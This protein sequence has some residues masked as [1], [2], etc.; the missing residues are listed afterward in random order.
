MLNAKQNKFKARVTGKWT[1]R[2]FLLWK[3]PIALLSGLQIRALD[4]N[5]SIVSIPYKWL[6]Q[7]PFK[8]IYFAS[9]A[10]AAEMSTGVLGMLAIQGIAPVSMLV[11]H[12]ECTFVKKATSRVWFT[13][14]NGSEIFEAVRT[15]LETGEGVTVKC[16][17]TGRTQDGTIVS[18]FYI[19][20]T[21]KR[22]S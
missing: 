5:H 3:L 1:F 19:T 10:M 4:E 14:E 2:L 22:R 11:L 17:A 13:C 18:N 8:S 15:T 16:T 6:T 21:F 20:W 9:Q 12:L 7:N